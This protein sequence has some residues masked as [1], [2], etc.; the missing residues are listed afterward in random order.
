MKS[1]SLIRCATFPRSI[2]AGARTILPW[3][4]RA[5]LFP[6]TLA[7]VLMI[8]YSFGMC[9]PPLNTAKVGTEAPVAKNILSQQF[10][11]LF[12]ARRGEGFLVALEIHFYRAEAD[13][14]HVSDRLIGT[15]G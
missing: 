3:F 6:A 8:F 11:A 12:A 13:P 2:E 4:T 14:G 15:S 1:E 10:M 9:R 7:V 5:E